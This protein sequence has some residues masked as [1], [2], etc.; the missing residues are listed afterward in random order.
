MQELAEDEVTLVEVE[1]DGTLHKPEFNNPFT[2]ERAIR[3]F[4]H[5][6]GQH[7]DN[8]RSPHRRG[9]DLCTATPKYM[10]VAKRRARNK[11]AKQARKVNRGS[12]S[13]R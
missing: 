8:R 10:A 1:D 6:F 12:Y 13:G 7:V 4:F 11:V 2:D 5:R 9:R 3:G